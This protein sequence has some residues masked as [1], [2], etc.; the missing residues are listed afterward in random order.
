MPRSS[1]DE[2]HVNNNGLLL[3]DFCKQTGLRIMN[4]RVGNDQGIG[5]Y[6]FVG[7]RGRSLVDYVLSSQLMFKFIKDFEVQEPNILSDHCLDRFC[8]VFSCDRVNN[9]EYDQYETVDSKYKGNSECKA[10]FILCLQQNTIS[11]QLASLNANISNCINGDEIES[12]VSDFVNII[13]E[14]STPLFKKTFQNP[15]TNESSDKSFTNKSD[16]IGLVKCVEKKGS[17][18]IKSLINLGKIKMM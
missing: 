6:T 17:V 12:C 11:D 18:F 7:S 15:A 10:E 13:D 9:Q 14:M 3:L 8:F 1:E 4:G 5:K 16:T 2:V